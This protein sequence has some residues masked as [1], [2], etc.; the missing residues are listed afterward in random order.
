M[1]GWAAQYHLMQDGRRSILK[2][3][4]P[5]DVVLGIWGRQ[6]QDYSTYALTAG[7]LYLF[8]RDAII[9]IMH[10]RPAVMFALLKLEAQQHNYFRE[11]VVTLTRLT[12]FE[13]AAYVCLELLL[14]LEAI[15]RADNNSFVLPASQTVLGDLL[16]LS[17]V[18][19]N[20]VFQ[21]LEEEGYIS[22]ERETVR[23][24]DRE[25]LSRIVES[26]PEHVRY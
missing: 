21:R 11:R 24:I 25:A 6:D 5:E 7:R 14:R 19:V 3:C 22:R 9:S 15:G 2:L 18:H 4:L 23:I 26:R 16:G 10:E 8:R 1:E 12:A 17:A 13:R 20:R